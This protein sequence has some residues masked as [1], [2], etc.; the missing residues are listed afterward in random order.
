VD[1]KEAPHKHPKKK[2]PIKNLLSDRKIAEILVEMKD[3]SPITVLSTDSLYTAL[4]TIATDKISSVPVMS[5]SDTTKCV[6][7]VDMMDLL[8][9]TITLLESDNIGKHWSKVAARKS[10]VTSNETEEDSMLELAEELLMNSISAQALADISCMDVFVTIPSE[11]NI[12]DAGEELAHPRHQRLAVVNESH[13]FMGV[14]TQSGFVEYMTSEYTEELQLS[15]RKV[16]SLTLRSKLHTVK[17]DASAFSA[18]KMMMEEKTNSLAV[19]NASG[20]LVD[21][22]SASD[23][24]LWT[25]WI[26]VGEVLRFSDI[27]AMKLNVERYLEESR[28]QREIGKR[29]PLTCTKTSSLEEVTS[30][31]LFHHVHQLFIVDEANIPL[32]VVTYADIIEDIIQ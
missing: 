19:V 1:E 13:K 17:E 6:G 32:G 18:F 20:K 9:A 30:D 24:M 22:I 23:L 5:A 25:E 27:S 4:G 7:F 2:S 3:G 10:R 21:V 12:L 11:M 26:A 28:S 31:M 16:G 15:Q 8:S 29:T 14:I